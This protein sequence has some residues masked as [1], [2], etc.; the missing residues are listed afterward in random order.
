MVARREARG[1]DPVRPWLEWRTAT[2]RSY[3]FHFTREMEA[4]TR[5]AAARVESIDSSIVSLVGYAPPRPI[6]VV[7]DDPFSI[8]NGYALPFLDHPVSV[9]WA[10]PPDPR[11]DIGNYRTWGEMLAT[12]ELTHIAHLTRPSRNP[13]QRA[14]WSS[15]PANLGPISLK[16]PR[17]VYEGYATFIEGRISGTGRPNNVWRP[18]L[19]RQWAIEGHLPTYGQLSFSG[20]YQGGEFAYL[21]GSAFLEWL[22]SH[23]GDSSLVHVWRRMSARTNRTFDASFA[24]V[25]GDPPAVLYG[26]HAAELTRD[27]MAARAR[28]ERAGLVEGALVQHLFWETGDPALSPDGARVAVTV[29]QVDRPSSVVIWSTAPD[30]PDTAALRRRI[31]AQVRDPQDVPDRRV[32]PPPKKALKML[33]ARNGFAFAR[34][35][36]LPDGKQI[37]AT[38]WAPRSDGTLRPDLFIW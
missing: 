5:A 34:P 11:N 7:V 18:A 14:L 31:E 32:Y 35:R 25:F 23:S 12:H 3:R 27:A 26:R 1:Q 9:W 24:G 16:A 38:R 28:L 2:T 13:F 20:D 15:L 37:L 22:T 8:A 36:W 29:R 17:W 6:D 33:R 30:E 19:L 10:T 21:N 4:W